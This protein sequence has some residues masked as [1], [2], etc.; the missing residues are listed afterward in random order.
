MGSDND[1]EG[2]PSRLEFN[3]ENPDGLA[4]TSQN[5]QSPKSVFIFIHVVQFCFAIGIIANISGMVSYTTIQFENADIG[6]VTGNN[7]GFFLLV[8]YFPLYLYFHSISRSLHPRMLVK[9]V[10]CQFL[11]GLTW[12]IVVLV[13]IDGT[14]YNRTIVHFN[15]EPITHN[16]QR[17][18]RIVVVKPA[19]EEELLPEILDNMNVSYVTLPEVDYKQ[20]TSVRDIY[21]GVGITT[22]NEAGMPFVPEFGGMATTIS[23]LK[24]F[25]SSDMLVDNVEWV[26]IMNNNAKPRPGF[27]T[28]V[29]I[30]M[31]DHMG[32]Y[33]MIW[34]DSRGYASY[35]YSPY[36][37]IGCCM[38]AVMINVK[39]IQ[40]VIN[41]LSP[42]HHIFVTYYHDHEECVP[43][44]SL[45]LAENCN[46]GEMECT[47]FPLVDHT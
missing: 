22:K 31:D 32:K 6:Y 43:D 29:E 15:R 40:N 8:G 33:D 23:V 38:D 35:R 3:P 4:Q 19:H 25:M 17:S 44:Q 9:N 21:K 36:G 1:V 24:R 16:I 30:L 14:V 10:V 39:S 34:L 46:T 20:H 41:A 27:T 37:T 13:I 47:V 7:A 28:S 12:F 45:L 42:D 2:Q 18:T 26:L 5:K 11:V